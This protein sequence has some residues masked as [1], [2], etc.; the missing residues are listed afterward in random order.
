MVSLPWITGTPPPPFELSRRIAL[1][2]AGNE[3]PT[4]GS[5]PPSPRQVL[6][7]HVATRELSLPSPASRGFCFL[8]FKQEFCSSRAPEHRA[9]ALVL[10]SV[11]Q[12]PAPPQPHPAQPPPLHQQ[13]RSGPC[14]G[15]F[16]EL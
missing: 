2:A 3:L 14:F 16:P 10:E 6:E 12:G 7:L 11:D 13:A 5:A 1:S 8:F 15:F 4:P 9:A